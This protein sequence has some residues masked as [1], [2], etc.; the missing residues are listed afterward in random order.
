MEPISTNGE[1]IGL[2]EDEWRDDPE[3]IAA[4]VAAVEQ[5][6]APVWATGEREEYERYREL[7][8]QFNIDAVHKQMDEIPDG[9]GP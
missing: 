3:S 2:T 7:Q 4:W 5:I 8:R 6:E 1:K 9:D